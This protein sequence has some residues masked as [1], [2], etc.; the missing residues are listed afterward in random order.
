MTG[1]RFWS[2]SETHLLPEKGWV[3][4]SDDGLSSV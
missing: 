4:E 3:L 2:K 1:N